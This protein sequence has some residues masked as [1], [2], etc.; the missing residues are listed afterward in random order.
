MK[1]VAV[2]FLGG[3]LILWTESAWANIPVP[4]GF[5]F[6]APFW[7]SLK[8]LGLVF[9]GIVMLEA[10]VARFIGKLSWGTATKLVIVT[11]FL[12]SAVGVLFSQ[13]FLVGLILLALLGLWLFRRSLPEPWSR[14]YWA[15]VLGFLIALGTLFASHGVALENLSLAVFGSL[16]PA[17]V[18]TV[19][20]ELPHWR[21][22][23]G[24][25]PALRGV[26]LSNLLSYS[27][28]VGVLLSADVRSTDTPLISYDFYAT[29]ASASA[30]AGNLEEA[31]ATKGMIYPC[32]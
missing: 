10:I 8:T 2:T 32:R 19:L 29:Q 5:G 1:R 21:H 4:G 25:S 30:S 17:F 24:R 14:V 31:R 26:L 9:V 12:S 7:L 28:L 23:I 16:V 20:L 11:N 27:L 22:Q 18:V 13:H 6:L 3:W 15:S